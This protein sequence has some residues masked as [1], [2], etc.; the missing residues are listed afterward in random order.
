M[1]LYLTCMAV[2]AVLWIAL[3]LWSAVGLRRR[4]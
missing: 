2:G 4:L 3:L 1:R